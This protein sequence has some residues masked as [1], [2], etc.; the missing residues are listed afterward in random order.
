[1]RNEQTMRNAQLDLSLLPDF[2][3]MR[4]QAPWNYTLQNYIESK[5][6]FE[7]AVVFARLFWPEFVERSGCILRADV[8]NEETFERWW[9]EKPGDIA[10]IECVLNLLHVE[11]LIPS[12]NTP[13]DRCVYV[14]L[15]Q[16]LVEMWSA[17]VKMLYPDREF[18]VRCDECDETGTTE[19]PTVYLYQKR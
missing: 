16:T 4:A 1:M 5:G 2:S 12:D 15:A 19:G 10:A 6:S 14:H 17:R 3:A 18:V 7:L 8:F 13:L 11:E 9:Q